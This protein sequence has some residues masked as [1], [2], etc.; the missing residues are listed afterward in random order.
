MVPEHS[1]TSNWQIYVPV[2][3][4]VLLAAGVPP[5]KGVAVPYG[6]GVAEGEVLFCREAVACVATAVDRVEVG[7]PVGA[8]GR[9]EA[10]IP[11]A[12]SRSSPARIGYAGKLVLA[13]LRR[14]IKRP[15]ASCW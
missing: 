7:V 15:A 10:S 2:T 3:V 1:S 12:T 11:Q 9:P 8:E 5:A 6:V 14:W 4:A 13:S